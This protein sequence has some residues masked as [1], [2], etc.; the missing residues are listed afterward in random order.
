MAVLKG[1]SSEGCQ[2]LPEGEVAMGKR[3]RENFGSV[4]VVGCRNRNGNFLKIESSPVA[5]RGRNVAL[6][7]PAGVGGD[8]WRVFAEMLASTV[9]VG[10]QLRPP[11]W[12]QRKGSMWR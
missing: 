5:Q 4:M 9:G 11:G 12:P 7:I 6:C 10:F 1:F 3:W 2:Q 8:G